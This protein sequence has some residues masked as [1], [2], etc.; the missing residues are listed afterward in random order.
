MKPI[1]YFIAFMLVLIFVALAW[2]FLL[3]VGGVL[4]SILLWILLITFCV[5]A[6]RGIRDVVRNED[7]TRGI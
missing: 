5:G 3:V 2:R 4:L 7:A 6:V 1:L